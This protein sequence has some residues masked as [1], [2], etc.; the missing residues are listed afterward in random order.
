M[1]ASNHRSPSPR[2]RQGFTRVELSV[3]LAVLALL[4]GVRL[5]AVTSQK[6]QTK[7]TQCASN[8]RQLGLSMLL[9]GSDNAEKLPAQTGQGNWL[10]DLDWNVGETLERYGTPPERMFCP[11]TS[12]RFTATND[13]E[14]YE[15][16]L[17]GRIHVIGYAPT[18][19]GSPTLANSNVNFT[20][21]PQPVKPQTFGAGYTIP[22]QPASQRVLAADATI[23]HPGTPPNYVQIAGGYRVFH[24][25]PHLDGFIPAGGNVIMLDGHVQWRNFSQMQLRTTSS[26][27]TLFY[28]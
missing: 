20:L 22:P 25:C 12:P 14:L 21:T 24:I 17:P 15:Y 23:T 5:F 27:Q 8:L 19:P 7:I 18:L 10:W 13:E 28:W 4:V 2:D 9:Y 1:K 16:Y 26:A 11:G 3:V 6:N